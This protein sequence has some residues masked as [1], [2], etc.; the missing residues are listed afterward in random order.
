MKIRIYI[1]MC[2]YE[3]CTRSTVNTNADDVQYLISYHRE[4]NTFTGLGS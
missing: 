2:M 4:N 3:L 1:L